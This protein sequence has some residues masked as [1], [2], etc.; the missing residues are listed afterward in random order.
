MV[1]KF[2]YGSKLRRTYYGEGQINMNIANTE[3]L[4]VIRI[5]IKTYIK[6]G[7]FFDDSI[8]AYEN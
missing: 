8:F 2:N 7:I 5:R 4:G 1:Y 3:G 6:G